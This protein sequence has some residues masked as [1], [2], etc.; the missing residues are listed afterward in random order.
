MNYSYLNYPKGKN[1]VKIGHIKR[2]YWYSKHTLLYKGVYGDFEP[3]SS[4][5]TLSET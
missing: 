3:Y 2:N 1:Y 4:S 5:V